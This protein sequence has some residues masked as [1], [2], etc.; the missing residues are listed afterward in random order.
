MA[1]GTK[2]SIFVVINERLHVWQKHCLNSI[3]GK[4]VCVH[5]GEKKDECQL[6]CLPGAVLF[7]LEGTFLLLLRPSGRYQ[8]RHSPNH[9]NWSLAPEYT[10]LEV[11]DGK[12][13]F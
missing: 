1:Y 11:G 6:L 2:M 7:F 10:K 13:F 8:S 9:R 3:F 12:E 5:V 4:G